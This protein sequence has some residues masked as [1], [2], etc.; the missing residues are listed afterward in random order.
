MDMIYSNSAHSLAKLTNAKAQPSTIHFC[1]WNICQE[2]ELVSS[3]GDK[4]TK[5]NN[6]GALIFQ[7]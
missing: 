6:H 4:I 5:K 2:N 1:S 3:K 7:K